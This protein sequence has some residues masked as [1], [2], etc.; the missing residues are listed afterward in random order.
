MPVITGG[1][2]GYEHVNVAAQRRDPDSFLN[3]LERVCRMRKEMPEVGWGDF[4]A[5]ASPDPSVLILRYE[6][7]NNAVVFLHNFL[8]EPREVRFRPGADRRA[9]GTLVNVLSDDHSTTDGNGRHTIVLEPYGYR[10]F[11]VGGLDYILRRS[12]T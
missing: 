2:Y 12:E 4:V 5:V 10:W 1:P 8:N 7:R 11:R 9:R 3:W 6:W